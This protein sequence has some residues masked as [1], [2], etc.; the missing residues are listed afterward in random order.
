MA[1][2]MSRA[3]RDGLRTVAETE[4]MRFSGDHALWHKHIHNVT[5]DPVQVLKCLEMDQHRNTIDFSCRRTGKTAIKELYQLK[6]NAT[7]AD[8]ELG[9]VG[10]REAQAIVNLNYHL[11]AI[12]RSPI[13]SAFIGQRG[14][15]PLLADTYY[16]FANGSRARAYGIMANVDGGDMTAAS[17]EEVDDMPRDRLYSRFLLMMGS[18]RRLGASEESKNDPQ[19]RVTGVFK[20]ADTLG[21]MIAGGK[22]HAL[23]T[24]DVN[25]GIELGILNAAFMQQMRDELDPDEYIRQLLCLNVSSKNHIWERKLREAMQVALRAG[26]GMVEPTPGARYQRRGLIAFGYDAGGHGEN[27]ASSR[28]ALVVAEMIGNWIFFPFVRAWPAGTD[29]SVVRGDMLELWRYFRPDAALGDAYGVGMLA[30]LND[31]LFR[32]R[33]ID[34]D[35]RAIGEGESTASTWPEWAFSPIRFEGMTKHQMAMALRGVFH[36]GHAIVPYFDDQDMRDPTVAELRTFIRQLGN[37]KS[38]PTKTSYPSYKMADPKKGDD[39]F[40]AACAA[41]WSLATRGSA[42]PGTVILTSQ[43]ERAQFLPA[44]AIGVP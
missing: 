28:H 31:D 16:Q 36:N 33:L 23:T 22:Y 37:V 12:R 38:T 18:T 34:I 5:L 24:I 42:N 11:E 6:E 32:E 41:V 14:N 27:P 29:E 40:D 4:I 2:R 9:I 10:P 20:G 3:R 1:E 7:T 35:R 26:F 30:P 21:D 25:L 15:R 19:I 13:L 39:Y 8:Q 17:L 43:R 44:G